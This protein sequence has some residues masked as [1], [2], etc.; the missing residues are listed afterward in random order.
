MM[1]QYF[2]ISDNCIISDHDIVLRADD[3]NLLEFSPATVPLLLV[4]RKGGKYS[5]QSGYSSARMKRYQ[6]SG[7]KSFRMPTM[8]LSKNGTYLYRQSEEGIQIDQLADGDRICVWFGVPPKSD[9]FLSN[10]SAAICGRKF[11]TLF[12][13]FIKTRIQ[14]SDH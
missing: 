2:N 13:T 5:I 6:T 1:I 9:K 14:L 10:T 8:L 4:V 12:Q 3:W 7:G 11:L